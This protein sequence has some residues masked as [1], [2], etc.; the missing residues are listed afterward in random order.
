M[1]N[2]RKQNYVEGKVVIITGASSGFGMITAQKV[3]ALGGIP[4]MAARREDRLVSVA[5][6]IEAAGGKCYYKATDISKRADVEALAAFA[7]EKCGKIDV[8]VNNA[9][10]M[11]LAKFSDHHIAMEKWEQCIDTSLKGTLYGMCAV[12]DQ[13]IEQGYGQII[14]ISSIYAKYPLEGSAVYQASKIGVEY[15]AESLREEAGGKIK[16]ATLRPSAIA[17]TELFDCIIN[18]DC[19]GGMMGAKMMEGLTM[20]QE[21]PGRPDL[22]DQDAMSCFMATPEAVADNI[23]FLI[24]QPWGINISDIT[25][26]GSNERWI[27]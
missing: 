20:M 19:A 2:Y 6:G 18:W 17:G 14:N 24:D 7:I 9:G 21:M 5:A 15:L 4:V 3:A 1:S 8:L 25:V 23:V 13:M 27:L 11:P 16:V 22:Q 10:T 26:R 12:Y